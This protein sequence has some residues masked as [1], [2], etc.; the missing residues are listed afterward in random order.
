LAHGY[1]HVR[2]SH[3]DVL[4]IVAVLVN[5]RIRCHPLRQVAG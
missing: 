3:R 4:A 5:R 1:R 2:E